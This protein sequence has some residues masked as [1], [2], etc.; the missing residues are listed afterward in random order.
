MARM[1]SCFF[2]SL[3]G[4]VWHSVGTRMSLHK[5]ILLHGKPASGT[6]GSGIPLAIPSQLDPAV[7]DAVGSCGAFP[8]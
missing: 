2:L 5:G 7:S 6:P 8:L 4:Q 3:P 1:L